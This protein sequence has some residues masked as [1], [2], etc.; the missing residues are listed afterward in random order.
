MSKTYH[1]HKLEVFGRPL[2]EVAVCLGAA[3]ALG[4]PMEYA[5]AVRVGDPD[6]RIAFRVDANERA[7]EFVGRR[8][9]L[10]DELP[11]STAESIQNECDARRLRFHPQEPDI[12][13][14]EA[15]QSE[16]AAEL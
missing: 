9:N 15:Q 16:P 6:D 13:G 2:R 12:A 1:A 11:L 14:Y 3:A 7:G 5:A 10:V 4:M 8:L